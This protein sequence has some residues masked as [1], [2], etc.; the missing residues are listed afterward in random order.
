MASYVF[1]QVFHL[2]PS[3]PPDPFPAYRKYRGEMS[4]LNNT[5]KSSGQC[6]EETFYMTISSVPSA[7][8]FDENRICHGLKG[9]YVTQQLLDVVLDHI[10]I[11]KSQPSRMI[12]KS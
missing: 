8:L 12:E 10:L 1:H 5:R 11:H 2:A 7:H 3:K 9:I 6:R 4:K